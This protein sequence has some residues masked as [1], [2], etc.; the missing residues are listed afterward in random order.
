MKNLPW[1][2]RLLLRNDKI[3]M[4]TVTAFLA[5]FLLILYFI[6][7]EIKIPPDRQRLIDILLHASK[8]V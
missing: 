5:C 1:F 7:F 4:I 2:S 8:K 6:F 3:L